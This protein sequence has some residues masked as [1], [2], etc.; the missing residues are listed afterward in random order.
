MKNVA[1]AAV[2]SGS[3][4]LS[5]CLA[6]DPV[7]LPE[8]TI[9]AAATC[10]AAQGLVLRGDKAET[11][12]VTYEEFIKAIKY[13]MIASTQVEPFSVET[14][15]K[16]LGGAEAKAEEIKTKDYAGAVAT[17]DERF[18]SSGAIK[19]PENNGDAVLS[20][21]GIA[22]FI[23]GAVQ[24]QS[25]EFGG[26][27]EKV[28][29]LSKRLETEMQSDPELLAKM[30]GGDPTALMMG[31][32]KNAFASGDADGYVAACDARFPAK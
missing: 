24:S 20:C 8:D 17:C 32:L 21:M 2:L 9:E 6:G 7:E 18:K 26:E 15:L 28:T 1:L 19:L 4:V 13:P 5:G 31:A 3:L 14:V 12:P 27:A 10:F 22:S 25:S 23:A 30:I 11:D 16:I 29:A